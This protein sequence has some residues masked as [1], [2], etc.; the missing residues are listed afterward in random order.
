M[1]L[2]ADRICDAG[3][4]VPGAGGPDEDRRAGS[5]AADGR[6]RSATMRTGEF[7]TSVYERVDALLL[8]RSTWDIWEA[9][10]PHHDW[11]DPVS[12]GI[13]VV[14]KY[15]PSTTLRNPAWDNTHVLSDDVEARVRELKAQPGRDLLLQGSGVLLQWLLERDLVDQLN[16]VIYPLVLGKGQRLFPRGRPDASPQAAQLHGDAER[17]H[18]PDLSARR[19]GDVRHRRR[20]KRVPR[21]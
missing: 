18:D 2:V 3:R 15:V 19:A 10:W 1:K 17:G 9:Y 21:G 7:I 16:L 14:P 6:R 8:G 20:V 11:G 4:R 12:H 13:N 5:I